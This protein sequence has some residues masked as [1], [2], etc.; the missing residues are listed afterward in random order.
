MKTQFL[1]HILL[2][3]LLLCITFA[4]FSQVTLQDTNLDIGIRQIL[5]IDSLAVITQE[6]ADS[7]VSIDGSY[8][9]IV[10]LGGIEHFR[11]LKFL[12]L[13]GN[14]ITDLCPITFLTDLRILDVSNNEI[15]DITPLLL[16]ASN[17]MQINL[18]SNC[19]TDFDI[20]QN[21][22]MTDIEVLGSD[23]QCDSSFNIIY[24]FDAKVLDVANK[25]VEFIYKA[26]GYPDSLGWLNYGNGDSI[27][28]TANGIKDTITIQY[29]NTA[30]LIARLQVG[31]ASNA[32]PIDLLFSDI[33]LIS[34]AHEVT[35][36]SVN[37]EFVWHSNKFSEKY[38]LRL[39]DA[40][41]EM[42]QELTSIKD[43]TFLLLLDTLT[44]GNTYQWMVR[45]TSG[46]SHTMW[47]EM[48]Q[49]SVV[50][51]T[52]QVIQLLPSFAFVEDQYPETTLVNLND[53]FSDAI[54]GNPLAF[55]IVSDD[56]LPDLSISDS[57]LILH[58]TLNFAGNCNFRIKAEDQG[59]L[60]T[61]ADMNINIEAVNDTPLVLSPVSDTVLLTN[62]E[63]YKIALSTVFCDP[64]DDI[65]GL[66]FQ[67]F[68]QGQVVVNAVIE[69]DTL[70]ISPI[71]DG[72]G[73]CQ[74]EIV[75]SDGEYTTAS[76]FH[77]RVV[78][79]IYPF[80]V[81][82]YLEG[83][84]TGNKMSTILDDK[85]FIPLE[86]PFTQ[87]P[88]NYTEIEA[89]ESLPEGEIVDWILV[90]LR[91]ADSAK[92]ADT[93]TIVDRQAGFLLSSGRVIDAH[94]NDCVTFF[95]KVNQNPF[96][97]LWLRN[98]LGV[99]SNQTIEP[100]NELYFYNFSNSPFSAFG[101]DSTLVELVP[102]YYGLVGGDMNA[103]GVIDLLDKTEI[104]NQQAGRAGYLQGDV[105]L[106]GQADNIDK[107]NW[108]LKN[109]GKTN[110]VPE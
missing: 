109:R 64:D 62:F 81:K 48:H 79:G 106:D 22:W 41:N 76:T 40:G 66:D 33:E 97:T 98:Y 93:N 104:W 71:I 28:I 100:D 110:N 105:N 102:G 95:G 8:M 37:P 51:D 46:N 17:K 30:N 65:T 50:N 94:G 84:F 36:P 55:K 4:G 2:N 21:N 73:D 92:N 108:W 52:P 54:P 42:V 69:N 15:T 61:Y 72:L 31:K 58:P 91:D 12:W 24:T 6:M 99:I 89:I 87:E 80:L 83:A 10:T 88:W 82:L 68:D 60:F 57:L 67:I 27:Q 20:V 7:L 39:L 107:N 32:L 45:G 35:I 101:D 74:I 47:S 43:T 70:L 85:G 13:S 16:C 90:E 44:N 59:N 53:Y 75:A 5:E 25:N 49:F 9:G 19:I 38:H 18:R 34:P 26:Y 1:K 14:E 11:N 78:E 63:S 86:N 103:D 23:R 77:I 29:Q 3:L 56:G 96:I